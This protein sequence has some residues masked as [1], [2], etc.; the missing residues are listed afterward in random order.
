MPSPDRAPRYARTFFAQIPESLILG[1]EPGTIAELR[2]YAY[3]DRRA[4][5][6]GWWH[7]SARAIAVALSLDSRSVDRAIKRLEGREL[8]VREGRCFTLPERTADL[9]PHCRGS[10]SAEVRTQ[11]RNGGDRTSLDRNSPIREPRSHVRGSGS[12]A[13]DYARVVRTSWPPEQGALDLGSTD[14]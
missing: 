12:A 14:P 6:R 4:G 9:G 13:T 10:G 8:L 11:I 7:D 3:L 5:E 1:P 2:V